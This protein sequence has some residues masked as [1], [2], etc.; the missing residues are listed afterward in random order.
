MS[1]SFSAEIDFTKTEVGCG[2]AYYIH[3]HDEVFY[4]KNV[5]TKPQI[6]ND[7]TS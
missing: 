4:R 6:K 7:I 2:Y 3:V 5:L 1:T